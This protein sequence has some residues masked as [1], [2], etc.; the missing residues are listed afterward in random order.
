[1]NAYGK[2]GEENGLTVS[3]APLGPAVGAKANVQGNEATVTF[4]SA[5]VNHAVNT[6][7]G[8]FD[9]AKTAAHEVDH[10]LNLRADVSLQNT[11]SLSDFIFLERS[12]WRT[13]TYINSVL[14]VPDTSIAA[15]WKPGSGWDSGNLEW[16]ARFGAK[17]DCASV[18]DGCTP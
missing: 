3:V 13:Q 12:A 18:A 9:M 17:L 16:W 7:R 1:M 5:I 8:F 2:M 11:K 6:K 10:V 15:A 14:G 4:N